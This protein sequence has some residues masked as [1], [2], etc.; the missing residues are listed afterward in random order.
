MTEKLQVLCEILL[1]VQLCLP[2]ISHW[3]TWDGNRVSV[4]KFGRLIDQDISGH[5]VISGVCVCVCLRSSS[6]CR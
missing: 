3:V 6:P 2:Q 5:S 1:R 4:M